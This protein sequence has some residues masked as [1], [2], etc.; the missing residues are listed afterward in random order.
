MPRSAAKNAKIL[1]EKRRKILLAGIKVFAKRGYHHTRVSEIAREAGVAYGLIYHYFKNKRDILNTIFQEKWQ[2]F[3]QTIEDLKEKELTLKEKLYRI[4]SFIVDGYLEM[5]E[6]MDLLIL[7]LARSP[8]FLEKQ[9][10]KLFEK[11][12]VELE[13]L[14]SK[15]QQR[16]EIKRGLNPRLLSFIFFGA[17]ESILTGIV[18][19]RFDKNPEQIEAIK[20]ELIRALTEGI[21]IEK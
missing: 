12:F 15:G 3:T 4:L 10:L 20:T 16:G 13:N 18:M 19:K 1:E 21:L 7:E 9:N 11:T 6:L 8:K 2:D 5:P 17:I 14:L